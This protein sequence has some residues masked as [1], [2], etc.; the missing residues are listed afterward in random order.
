M[1][2]VGSV[3]LVAGYTATGLSQ[4]SRDEEGVWIKQVDI[5]S[6]L[7]GGVM[8]GGKYFFRQGFGVGFGAGPTVAWAA[9]DNLHFDRSS[10]LLAMNY[11]ANL[12]FRF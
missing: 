9:A 10:L 12:V 5:V 7:E 4:R 1:G 6:G 11:R 2:F 3:R 8:L